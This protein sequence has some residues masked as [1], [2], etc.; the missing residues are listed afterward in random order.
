M[1]L[2]GRRPQATAWQ[3]EEETRET[4]DVNAPTSSPLGAR[5]ASAAVVQK[6]MVGGAI[7]NGLLVAAGWIVFPPTAHAPGSWLGLAA[8]T[9][10]LA[11]YG[12]MGWKAAALTARKDPRI[13]PAALVAG[14]L[15]GLIFLGEMVLEYLLLS[16]ENTLYGILEFGAV[17][18][19]YFLTAAGAGCHTGRISRAVSSSV[20][21]ALIG[22][23]VFLGALLSISYLFH[24]T[25]RQA[26]VFQAEGNYEDFQRSGLTDF[27]AFVMQDLMGA[28]FFHSLLL[29][30]LAALLGVA[31]GAVGKGIVR[32][33]RRPPR[34]S[35][36]KP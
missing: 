5:H 28:A 12:V 15:S 6:I 26:R 29:P 1:D 18:S 30:L 8:D 10:V 14:S 23:T 2:L 33:Y 36:T 22:S 32:L 17:L 11:L 16:G 31:G 13:L 20:W 19:V 3:Y 34:E 25:A 27:D 24:G 35:G 9:C 21:S 4:M 7:V